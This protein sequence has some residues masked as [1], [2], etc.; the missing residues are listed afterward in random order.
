[1]VF[2]PGVFMSYIISGGNEDSMMRVRGKSL[3]VFAMMPFLWAVARTAE[4]GPKP[5]RLEGEYTISVSGQEIGAEKYAVVISG[6][7]A[8]SVSTLE[9]RNPGGGPKKVRLE[10]K[11]EMDANFIPRS[12]ELKSDVDGQ[13]GRIVGRFAPNQVIF[14]YTGGG[15]SDRSGLLLGKQ[16]TVLDTNLFHHFIFLTRL[17]KYDSGS[18]PQSFDVVIPQE[19]D[20]GSLKIREL[21][22]E[23]ILVR[24]KKVSTAHLLVDSGSLQIHLW[25]DDNHVPR[26][27][28]VPD[29]GIEV[30]RTG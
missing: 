16:F 2:L 19:K 20:T 17:F 1:M 10:S 4:R 3:V 6:D 24:G 22:R 21:G 18:K 23:T 8:S 25:V 13:A 29:R 7:T 12:Y 14:E 28:A 30:L 11:M 5:E 15:R 9:F 26:K 27:I